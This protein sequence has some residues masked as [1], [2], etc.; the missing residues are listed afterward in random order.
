MARV[1]CDAVIKALKQAHAA[2][3]SNEHNRFEESIKIAESALIA[4]QSLGSE[5]DCSR[6]M[7]MM[8]LKA[9]SLLIGSLQKLNRPQ[10]AVKLYAM[11][12]KRMLLPPSRVIDGDAPMIPHCDDALEF[13]GRADDETAEV[14]SR[15]TALYARMTGGGGGGVAEIYR[16]QLANRNGSS[17]ETINWA[18][19]ALQRMRGDVWIAPIARR[20]IGDSDEDDHYMESQTI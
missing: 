13:F 14:I 11:A 8:G 9:E 3:L 12:D 6:E 1:L 19:L 17:E 2:Y 16:A 10:E 15:L 5:T 20:L 18:R 7:L 4:I